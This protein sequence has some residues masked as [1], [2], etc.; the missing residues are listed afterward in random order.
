MQKA[1]EQFVFWGEGLQ[2]AHGQVVF[3]RVRKGAT[4]FSGAR[5]CSSHTNKLCS[6]AR[7]WKRDMKI[8]I[9]CSWPKGYHRHMNNF[10]FGARDCN[11]HLNSLCS[12]SRRC[13]GA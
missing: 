6:G 11:R 1:H 9:L 3:K 10:C 8:N 13:K 2:Q 4:L 5:G 12:E 7:G